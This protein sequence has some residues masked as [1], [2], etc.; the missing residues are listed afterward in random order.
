[1][2]EG[3][4]VA[5]R[6]QFGALY[7]TRFAAGFGFAT[8]ATLLPTYINLY[9]PSGLVLG[10]FYTGFTVAQTAAVV[11][12]AWAGDRYDKRT[13]LLVGLGLSVLAYASFSLAAG[14]LG[15]V[16]ARGLQGLGATTTGIL[17]LAMVGELA[18]DDE[19]ANR[20]GRANAFRLAAGVGGALSAG[21][22]YQQ[23]SFDVVYGVLVVLLLVAIVGVAAFV[24]RDSTRVRG[25]PFAGLALNERLLTLTSFRAQYSVAVTLVRSWVLVYAGLDALDGGLGYAAF[26]VAVL[27]TA[28]RLTNMLC[29]PYSG[30]LSDRY[31]RALFVFLGGGAYGLVALLVPF[32]PA[33]GA[34]VGA[35][36]AI[37]SLAGVSSA[38]LDLS[39]AFVPL[40]VCNGLLGVADSVREPASMA[41]FADEGTDDGGV[42]SSFGIREL[43]WRPGSV[44]APIAAGLLT[45]G[46]GIEYVFYLGGGAALTAVVTFLGVLSWNHGRGALTEW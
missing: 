9:D 34:T 19:R 6:A 20:I 23:Y 12:V 17:S 36:T 28:E 16:L 14:S 4:G 46:P 42:A 3:S 10:L 1:M 18:P 45:T 44:L 30:A 31:G 8:L 15:V 2:D 26:V 25:N 22:L 41:L 38:F 35:P 5:G 40:V 13:V 37:P 24:E 43:V 39:P 21:Y 32:T 11:P 7:L 27:Y 33:I 29:Q